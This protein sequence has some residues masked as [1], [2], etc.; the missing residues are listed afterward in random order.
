MAAMSTSSLPA[1][2]AR[3]A[4]PLGAAIRGISGFLW[5]Q[6]CPGC[7]AAPPA[8]AV[9]CAECEARIPR[10]A[11][12]LCARCLAH[13]AADPL[14]ARHADRRV[15]P[16]WVY[17]ERA[18]R[19]IEA[20]K[21][22]SRTDLARRLGAELARAAAAGPRPDLVTEVPLHPA[23]RRER[24]Y[25]QSELLAESLADALGVPHLRGALVR[26]RATAAQARLGP[27]AR[28]ANVRAAFRARHPARLEGR[29]VLLVDDV[30]TTGATLEACLAALS[31]AGAQ[32]SAVA[33]AWAQ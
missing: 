11:V 17:D 23:R 19:V 22:S 3:A 24:G 26:V 1:P 15:R 16:A 18:A 25:N 7:G 2:I 28:R 14:C 9:L 32:P 27:A 21:Y 10:L 29:R 6:R 4:A 5:P 13:E 12:A 20:L 30:I 31:R 33:L 8:G